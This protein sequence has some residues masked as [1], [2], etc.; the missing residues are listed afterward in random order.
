MIGRVELLSFKMGK[1]AST[2]LGSRRSEVQLRC[3]DVKMEIA[4]RQ[5]NRG[6]LNREVRARDINWGVLSLINA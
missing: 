1:T 6:S 4:N 2:G 5:L 3:L